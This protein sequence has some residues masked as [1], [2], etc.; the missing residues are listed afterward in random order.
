[1]VLALAFKSKPGFRNLFKNPGIIGFI[2]DG[3]F[4]LYV[5]N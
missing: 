3:A 4:D 1:M 5:G 2:R